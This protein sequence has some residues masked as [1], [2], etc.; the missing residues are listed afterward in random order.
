MKQ[1][2]FDIV[3]VPPTVSM[4]TRNKSRARIV[5]VLSFSFPSNFSTRSSSENSSRSSLCFLVL[6]LSRAIFVY[7]DVKLQD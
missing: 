3:K 1:E 2:M 6:V 4:P 7:F 5:A